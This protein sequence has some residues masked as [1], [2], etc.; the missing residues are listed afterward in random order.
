[1]AIQLGDKVV[2]TKPPRILRGHRKLRR[3]CTRCSGAG[4]ATF[5]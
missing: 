5:E 3:I 2:L 1:M 4:L